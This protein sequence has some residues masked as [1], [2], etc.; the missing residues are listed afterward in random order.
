MYLD[1]HWFS[2]VLGGFSIGLAY[3]LA[4]VWVIGSMPARSEAQVD[5]RGDER[6]GI[7]VDPIVS[8]V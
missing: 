8:P 7:D 4:V 1:A 5:P 6:P 2:D 3:L